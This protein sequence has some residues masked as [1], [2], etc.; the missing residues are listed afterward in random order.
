MK[1]KS[2]KR[3]LVIGNSNEFLV[4][5]VINDLTWRGFIIEEA[6]PTATEVSKADP[7]IRLYIL[8]IKNVSEL[9]EILVFLRDI[10]FDR[11]LFVTVICNH[12]EKEEIFRYIPENEISTIF[13]RPVNIKDI[14]Q[15]TEELYEKSTTAEQRKAILI[16]DDDPTFLHK[17]QQL[18]KDK[19][20]VYM[21]NS[22]ASA[23]MI[24]S[25]HKADLI[26]LD[27]D[28]PIV[29]GPQAYEMIKAEPTAGDTPIMFL[30]GK[31]D[32]E[33]I[34]TARRLKPVHYILKSLPANEL[35]SAISYFFLNKGLPDG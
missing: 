27:Y 32:P 17:T 23:I 24:L 19:Y 3:V 14:G 18:L 11:K 5:S 20:K 15:N 13:E 28:M 12:A 22:A 33:S 26:L 10:I 30:T 16:I 25:K 29:S 21:A 8:V 6:S 34:S 2:V 9:S 4:R 7:N 35:V 31:N 1:N